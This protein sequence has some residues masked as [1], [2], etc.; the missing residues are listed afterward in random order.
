MKKYLFFILVSATLAANAEDEDIERITISSGQ[1]YYHQTL[2]NVSPPSVVQQNPSVIAN[3]VTGMVNDTPYINLN[4]QGG[5]F[6]SYSLRGFSRWRVRTL[7]D[8][9]PIYTERRAGTAAEFVADEFIR[10][11]YVMHGA[12]STYLGSGAMGGG[13]DFAFKDDTS[14]SASLAYGTNQNSRSVFVQHTIDQT[15]AM[16]N[17]K[18]VGKGQDADGQS[19]YDQYEQSSLFLRHQFNSDYLEDGWM[20]VS[21]ANNIGKSSSDYPNSRITL[22]PKNRH[23]LG[24][25]NFAL[26]KAKAHVYWH[27]SNLET[28]ITRLEERL[29][30]S[31]SSA[32]NYGGQ[33]TQSFKAEDWLLNGRAEFSIRDSV[34]IEEQETNLISNERFT[35][36]TLDAEQFGGAII[37]DASRSWENMSFAAGGRANWQLQRTSS[38][39]VENTN[40]SGFLG[41]YSTF[42]ETFSGRFFVSTAYRTPSL[43][44]RFFNGETPRGEIKGDVNLVAEK[45]LNV[46]LGLDYQTIETQLRLDFF[47]QQIDNYIERIEIS[48]DLLVYRNLDKADIRGMSYELNHDFG[49][50]QG[51]SLQLS[52]M[53]LDGENQA[54]DPIADVS[55]S[56]HR[57]GLKFA[58]NDYLWSVTLN[59]RQSKQDNAEGEQPLPSTTYISAGLNWKLSENT[60]LSF[61]LNN[62]TNK[63]YLASMDDKSALAHG[64]DLQFKIESQF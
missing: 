17:Y 64:R 22:Y 59:H 28:N 5:L 50:M 62:L 29:N 60:A 39:S 33:I 52:G 54:G 18:K 38:N 36:T 61:A 58:V 45:A 56:A 63:G 1:P 51:W 44:E 2:Q 31:Q 12:S 30:Q 13:I 40:F 11:V 19:L 23:W 4:G 20:L 9:V 46:Q 25:I 24:K 41:V 3:G 42:S 27:K 57:I 53:L 26:D 55:P 47:H 43:T 14:S 16:F 48:E 6:Q 34:V 49:E 8:G 32:F 7:I 37:I 21:D 35:G 10:S 15:D